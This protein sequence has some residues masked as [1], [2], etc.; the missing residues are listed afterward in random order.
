MITIKHYC[1]LFIS[2]LVLSSCEDVIELELNSVESQ[3]VIEA[4]LDASSQTAMVLI[5]QTND[6]YDTTKPEEISG[7]L[8]TLQSESGNTYTLSETSPG[9]YKAAD[10]V[11]NSGEH[12]D[13]LVEIEDDF[14]EA[15]A[16]TPIA[17]S[18]DS[19]IQSDF[20]RGPFSDEGDIRLLC[21][22]EDPI[23]FKNFYRLR[24]YID[25]EFQS[26]SYSIIADN[27]TGDGEKITS[28][29]R[30]LFNEDTTVK[31]ELLS[32][33]ES[34]YQYF[35]QLSSLSDEGNGSTS[36]YNPK[37]NFTNNALGYFG[38]YHRSVKEIEL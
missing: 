17:V 25:E 26:D 33:S 14:Y 13:L 30:Q 31:I 7:A 11:V 35:F 15:T 37:G 23:D 12:F 28:S 10:I 27:L 4:N 2:L 34:Y 18:L 9:T 3:V 6:F 8:I 5:S 22:W 36:P 19:I 20:S 21:V 32:T 24:T 16:Q 1:F 38:I 29:I